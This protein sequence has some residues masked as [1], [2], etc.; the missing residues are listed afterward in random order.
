MHPTIQVIKLTNYNPRLF[1]QYTNCDQL[2]LQAPIAM[3]KHNTYF[4]FVDFLNHSLSHIL[5]QLFRLKHLRRSGEGPADQ[6]VQRIAALANGARLPPMGAGRSTLRRNRRKKIVPPPLSI[7]FL[8]C[9][10]P[11]RHAKKRL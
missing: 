10:R 11:H 2:R 6:L 1:I 4:V 8:P 9:T 3:V 7:D 5:A